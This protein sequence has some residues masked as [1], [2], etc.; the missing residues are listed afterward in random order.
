MCLASVYERNR[1]GVTCSEPLFSDVA[2]MEFQKDG[3]RV[4]N[5]L[6]KSEIVNEPEPIHSIDFVEG[7]V[8][9]QRAGT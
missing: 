5:M 4:T 6:G 1:E 2:Y 9:L 7:T 8:I 3:L